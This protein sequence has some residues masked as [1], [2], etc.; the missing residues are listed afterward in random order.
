MRI[1][2][3][4]EVKR[5]A[6]GPMPYEKKKK[7]IF[8]THVGLTQKPMLSAVPAKGIS[9]MREVDASWEQRGGGGISPHL[10]R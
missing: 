2:S 10:P 8:L 5:L 6:Q 4:S 3:C 7:S 9:L 1:L